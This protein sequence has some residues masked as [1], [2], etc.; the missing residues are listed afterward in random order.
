MNAIKQGKLRL[1]L[2]YIRPAFRTSARKLAN[3]GVVNGFFYVAAVSGDYLPMRVWFDNQQWFLER[4]LAEKALLAAWTRQQN[5]Y[6]WTPFAKVYLKFYDREKLLK[7]SDPFPSGDSYTL[8]RG[9][10]GEGDPHGVSWT[11][12]LDIATHFATDHNR[13]MGLGKIYRITV[14]R[15]DVYAR[16]HESGREEHEM[17]LVLDKDMPLER[18][19]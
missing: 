14:P 4:D 7:Y 12:S 10:Q 6:Y 8:Y 16:I 1:R 19:S 3:A 15:A 2:R 5:T 13:F 9:V 11:T 18:I 17:L